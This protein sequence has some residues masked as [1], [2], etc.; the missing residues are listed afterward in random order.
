MEL[1]MLIDLSLFI[2]LIGC[3]LTLEGYPVGTPFARVWVPA[4]VGF[5]SALGMGVLSAYIAIQGVI[6]G[7]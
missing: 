2:I 6:L 3:F 7:Y 1:L 4:L 5:S